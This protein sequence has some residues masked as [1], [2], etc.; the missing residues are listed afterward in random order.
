MAN[1]LLQGVDEHAAGGKDILAT[2]AADGGGET[3]RGEVITEPDNGGTLLLLP[4][5]GD[6]PAP[7]C[8]GEEEAGDWW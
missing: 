4:L 3:V 6:T 1:L 7:T 5:Y 2:G 8:K